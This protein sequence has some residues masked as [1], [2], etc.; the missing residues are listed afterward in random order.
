MG[1]L[2]EEHRAGISLPKHQM[3]R[4]DLGRPGALGIRR[5]NGCRAPKEASASLLCQREMKR[6][7]ASGQV[8]ASI[9]KGAKSVVG[10][11]T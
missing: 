2:V 9:R 8:S 3:E 5:H 1:E 10:Q 4:K 7:G 11:E 6:K